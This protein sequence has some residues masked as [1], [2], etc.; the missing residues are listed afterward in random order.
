MLESLPLIFAYI[1]STIQQSWTLMTGC[2]VLAG[3]LAL[4]VLDR[5]FHIFDVIR[6]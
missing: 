5:L 6:R 4:A 2:S 3:F 1:I